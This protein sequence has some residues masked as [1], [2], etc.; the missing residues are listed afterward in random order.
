VKDILEVRDQRLSGVL[1]DFVYC[2]GCK[3]VDRDRNRGVFGYKCPLC[4]Y[5]STLASFY[6]PAAVWSLVDLIQGSYHL[7]EK[8]ASAGV[9]TDDS[10][11]DQRLAVVVFFCTLGEVLLHHFLKEYMSSQGLPTRLQERLLNDNRFVNERVEKLFPAL[12]GIKWKDAVQSLTKDSKIDYEK[13]VRF[14]RDT[15]QKRNTLL[16]QGDKLVIQAS[17]PTQCMRHIWPLLCLFVALHNR[18]LVGL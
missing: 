12:T 1:A 11:K 13:T 15:A 16:H 4:G 8:P 3:V 17:L 2:A 14:F 18:Y 10:L 5:P 6:F 9:Q 7:G